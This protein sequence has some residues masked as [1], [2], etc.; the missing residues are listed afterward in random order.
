[1][2]DREVDDMI[3][4]VQTIGGKAFDFCDMQELPVEPFNQSLRRALLYAR[5]NPELTP[6]GLEQLGIRDAKVEALLRMI[7]R[8]PKTL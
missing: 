1:M 7:S 6:D 5:Y 4:S 3:P 8:L 2:I